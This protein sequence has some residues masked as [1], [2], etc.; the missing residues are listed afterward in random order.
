MNKFNKSTPFSL[1]AYLYTA[2][3]KNGNG[4]PLQCSC[5]ENPKDWGA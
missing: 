5:L 3:D 2:S 1:T 4:S